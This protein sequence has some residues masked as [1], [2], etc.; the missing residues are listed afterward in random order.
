[1]DLTTCPSYAYDPFEGD[2]WKQFF[3]KRLPP[4]IQ[5]VLAP[6]LPISS[7]DIL[8]EI[9]DLI[10]HSTRT[11]EIQVVPAHRPSASHETSSVI[12]DLQKQVQSLTLMVESFAS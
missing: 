7:L 5:P 12:E 6:T 8:A 4:N 11:A 1:M 10:F 9:A 2:F 3:M